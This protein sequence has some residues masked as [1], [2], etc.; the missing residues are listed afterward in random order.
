MAIPL[1][2][3]LIRLQAAAPHPVNH[4]CTCTGF[5]QCPQ[6]PTITCTGTT[7]PCNCDIDFP[8]LYQLSYD[9]FTEGVSES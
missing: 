7:H 2:D 3:Y 9:V 5:P 1:S 4:P 8:A 6:N